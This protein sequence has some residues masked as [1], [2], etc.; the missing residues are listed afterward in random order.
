MR[1]GVIIKVYSVHMYVDV[2]QRFLD[3]FMGPMH[4]LYWSK[5]LH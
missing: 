1:D 2:N 5:I 3:I 4:K